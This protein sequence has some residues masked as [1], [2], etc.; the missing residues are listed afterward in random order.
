MLGLLLGPGSHAARAAPFDSFD[1]FDS[2]D[3]IESLDPLANRAAVYYSEIYDATAWLV[4]VPYRLAR[5]VVIRAALGA[6]VARL[7]LDDSVRA[8]VIEH[9]EAPVLVDEIVPFLLALK[10]TYTTPRSAVESFD[11]Q[12]IDFLVNRSGRSSLLVCNEARLARELS[13][14][15][16]AEL[17]FGL[18]LRDSE[19]ARDAFVGRDEDMQRVIAQLVE[20]SPQSVPYQDLAARGLTN[21]SSALLGLVSRGFVDPRYPC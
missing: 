15:A 11:T 5:P 6:Y 16:L 18:G 12:L 4:R 19:P 1:S 13:A 10:Q 2:F 8:R 3:A 17:Q 7:E 21:L 14:S 20:D 9:I